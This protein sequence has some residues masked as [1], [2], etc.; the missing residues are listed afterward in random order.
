[1]NM[2]EKL[3]ELVLKKSFSSDLSSINTTTSNL[4]HEHM[5]QTLVIK[6]QL[7]YHLLDAHVG[8]VGDGLFF[9]PLVVPDQIDRGCR[10]L[11]NETC[12]HHELAKA[13]ETSGLPANHA[14]T[15]PPM[16]TS[17]KLSLPCTY[18]IG[19]TAKQSRIRTR[20]SVFLK[21][22]LAMISDQRPREPGATY[23]ILL[24]R[25]KLSKNWKVKLADLQRL[26]LL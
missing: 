16:S 13:K 6:S 25:G 7:F 11:R 3:V 15:W 21:L 10:Y 9:L 4:R 14:T 2:T 12:L 23:M 22:N 1:M 8:K 20:R 19:K 17:K 24:A 26:E 5:S 18:F